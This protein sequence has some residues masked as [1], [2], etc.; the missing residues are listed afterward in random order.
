MKI[1]KSRVWTW[2]Q[3]LTLQKWGEVCQ[4]HSQ[5]KCGKTTNSD[6]VRRKDDWI[7][8]MKRGRRVCGFSVGGM[9]STLRWAERQ[10]GKVETPTLRVRWPPISCENVDASFNLHCIQLTNTISVTS[11]RSLFHKP[12][13]TREHIWRV[14][15]ETQLYRLLLFNC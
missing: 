5:W 11:L 10:A 8:C 13:H 12:T 15:E 2:Q 9:A 3:R 6:W 14:W 7:V 4:I 1:L